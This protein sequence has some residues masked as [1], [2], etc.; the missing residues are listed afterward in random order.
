MVSAPEKE[1]HPQIEKRIEEPG[2]LE[3]LEKDKQ[4]LE[5][6]IER[7]ER[8][9]A[10]KPV[11]DDQTGQVVLTPA[12]SQQVTVT[13]PLT[14][15]EMKHGLHHRIFDSMRWL[16]EWCLRM[17]KKALAAGIGVVYRKE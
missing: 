8:A 11:T 14:E 5:G 16:S 4:E 7:V 17:V 1:G 2:E 12:G 10:S 15:E 9:P 3:R 6:Y 13:L